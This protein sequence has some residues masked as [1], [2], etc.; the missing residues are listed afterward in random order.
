MIS[1]K[2]YLRFA[3]RQRFLLPLKTKNTPIGSIT[4]VEIH[5]DTIYVLDVYKSCCLFRFN[6][7]G[8]QIDVIGKRGNGPFEYVEPTDFA[9]TDNSIWIYDQFQTKC[10]R[11]A[12]DGTPLSEKRTSFFALQ[13]NALSDNELIFRGVDLDNLH[14]PDILNYQIWV[15]D[16]ADLKIKTAGVYRE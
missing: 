11:F 8:E 7:Q 14:L 1:G 4:K 10:I 16:T 12:H 9:V 5:N 15:C 2:H 13:M 3:V 6:M